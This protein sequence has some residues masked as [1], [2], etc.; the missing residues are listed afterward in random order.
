MSDA[1]R[2]GDLDG[3]IIEAVAVRLTGGGRID[4]LPKEGERVVLVVTGTVSDKVRVERVNGRLIRV[5]AVKA[6]QVAEPY[7]QL[8]SDTEAFLRAIAEA[9]DGAQAIPFDDESEDPEEPDA[10]G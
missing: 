8:A 5:H 2:F 4:R 1:P 10:S 7:D 9:A 3:E 6:E